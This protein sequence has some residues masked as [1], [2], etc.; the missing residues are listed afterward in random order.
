MTLDIEKY[1]REF[2]VSRQWIYCNHAAVAP[3]SNRVAEAIAG[4]LSDLTSF[5]AVHWKSWGRTVQ[6]TRELAAKLI[7]CD[8]GEIAFIKNTSDGISILSNGLDWKPGD[9]VVSIQTEFPSNVYP[10]LALE[11]RGVKLVTIPER[12]GRVDLAELEA[13]LDARTRVLTVSFVQYLS[14]FRVD[15]ARLGEVCRR[16]GI[17]FCVDAIQGLGAFDLNVDRDHIDFLAADAHKWMLATEG[18]G[19]AYVSNRILNQVTPSVLGWM[20]VEHYADFEHREL[21]YRRGALRYEPGSLNTIG[22]YGLA[23]ALELLLEAGIENISAQI[24]ATT[25][26]LSE[27][28]LRKRY[29]LLSSRRPGEASGIVSFRPPSGAASAFEIH[30][31]LEEARIS[32]AVRGGFIRLSPHFYNTPQEMD[33]ILRVLP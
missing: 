17:L 4:V 25:D 32:A 22:I 15:L 18:M 16:R 21:N 31:R 5:G 26:Y 8:P 27:G 10:W 23:A 19:V 28:L 30:R 11:R 24:L 33:E 14:G 6:H 1:R 3:I 2:P 7:R 9:K 12:H 29:A 13:A 20:S